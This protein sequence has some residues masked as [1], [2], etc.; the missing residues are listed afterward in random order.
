MDTAD[1]IILAIV[2]GVL[3]VAALAAFTYM[4]SRRR[5]G[6]RD[7]F[8]PEYDRTVGEADS[9]R[10]A[11]REL[12]SREQRYA[13]LEVKPLSEASRARYTEDWDHAERLFVDDPELA[14]RQ[15]DRL[16]R[17]VLDERGYPNDDLDTQTAAVSVEHPRAVQRY[18]HGHDMVQGNGSKDSGSKDSGSNG[19]DEQRTEN[20]RKA[21][22][23]F[24][25][26]FVEMVEPEAEPA[27]R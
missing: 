19:S 17:N 20:L 13:E 10:E 6:L 27:A 16:V 2:V 5:T 1:W 14:A 22:I 18:R 7:R 23:D 11:E 12:R 25:A 15:A 3:A 8:G 4:S 9:R 24:R 21:M 26:V